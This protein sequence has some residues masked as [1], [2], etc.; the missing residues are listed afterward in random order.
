[1][2]GDCCCVLNPSCLIKLLQHRFIDY[3]A[4]AEIVEAK[5]FRAALPTY[6]G[7][8]TCTWHISQPLFGAYQRSNC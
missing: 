2:D 7:C 6:Y 3:P 1:M 4:M 8:S 5:L